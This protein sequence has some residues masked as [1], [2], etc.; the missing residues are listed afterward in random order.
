MPKKVEIKVITIIPDDDATDDQVNE[1]I[2]FEL[3]TNGRIK[4]GNK[5]S[6]DALSNCTLDVDWE[7]QEAFKEKE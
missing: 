4:D 2:N 6:S 1:W 5:L 3:G 7:Y